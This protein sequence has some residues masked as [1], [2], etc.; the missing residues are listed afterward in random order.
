LLGKV[1]II[2]L[3]LLSTLKEKINYN[4]KIGC[5]SQLKMLCH[6]LP[7]KLLQQPIFPFSVTIISKNIFLIII[8]KYTYIINFRKTYY[9][10]LLK[11]L[12]F[13]FEEKITYYILVYIK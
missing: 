4:Q 9:V 8:L 2:T 10:I 13:F 5:C 3:F 7:F 11:N 1:I 6:I 12:F